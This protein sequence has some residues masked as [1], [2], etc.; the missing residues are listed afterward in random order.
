[1]RDMGRIG[2]LILT[3]L[4]SGPL[5][6]YG[7]IQWIEKT[8]EPPRRVAVGTMYTALDRLER[9]ELVAVHSEN[10]VDGRVRRSYELTVA[11]QSALLESVQALRRELDTAFDILG[12]LNGAGS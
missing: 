2:R 6:G 5:H 8:T 4:A 12:G 9:D 10:I 11:G 1:M 7:L 3:G